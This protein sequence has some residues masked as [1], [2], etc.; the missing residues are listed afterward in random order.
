MYRGKK[1][2][3]AGGDSGMCKK[4]E[5]LPVPDWREDNPWYPEG[6]WPGAGQQGKGRKPYDLSGT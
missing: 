2:H 3:W 1:G 4:G 5:I 6:I